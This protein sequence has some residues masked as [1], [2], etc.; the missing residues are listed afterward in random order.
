M[1]RDQEF[2]QTHAY[3]KTL[4]L[5]VL[6]LVTLGI[7][8]VFSSS[9]VLSKETYNHPFHFLIHQIIGAAL[10]FALIYLIL[11]I[12]P[13]FYRN[14]TFIYVL[15]FLSL[16]LLALCL[17]A[18]AFGGASRWVVFNNLRYQPSELAKISLVL[19]LAYSIDQKKEQINRI[20]NLA[21]LLIAIFA[22]IF[23]IL[24]EPDYSTAALILV[25]SVCLLFIGGLKLR[26]FIVPGLFSAAVFALYL[27]QS[28]YRIAR[29]FA[30]LSPEKDPLG[31]GFHVIQS[32]LAVGSGGLFR[33]SIG[34]SIQKLF[35]L[36]NAHTDFIYA[37][38][39]E[40]FGLIGTLSILALFLIILWRGL[41]ISWKAPSLFGQVAAA[42]LTLAVF[43]QAM[44]NI[45]VVLGLSPPTGLPLP[46]FSFGRSSLITT[47]FSLGIVLHI[48]QRKTNRRAKK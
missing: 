26:H 47:L 2:S 48:S 16:G 23:L 37:I 6:I 35:F 18:P 19:F 1:S 17:A 27:I 13:A 46:L 43:I 10:G 36:P 21:P 11:H 39:G 4:L 44:F 15:L 40:E 14:P 24:M 29:L 34:E 8:M 28:P 5:A 7:V 45:S 41:L 12:R 42:G 32:K 30:F 22:V 38:V 3:D 25:I 20:K 9:G 33:I 31:A